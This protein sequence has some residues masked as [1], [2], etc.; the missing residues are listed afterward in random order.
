MTRERIDWKSL[1]L[2]P[3]ILFLLLGIVPA[4]LVGYMA[5]RMQWCAINRDA[6]FDL[7][8]YDVAPL[9]PLERSVGELTYSAEPGDVCHLWNS[10]IGTLAE[11]LHLEQARPQIVF[12]ATG[13]GIRAMRSFPGTWGTYLY[14]DDGPCPEIPCTPPTKKDAEGRCGIDIAM[15]VRYPHWGEELGG[16]NGWHSDPKGES[17]E[18]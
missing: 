12:V 8:A 13:G 16:T 11:C 7:T 6:Q 4:W 3:P 2:T 5:A 10:V 15:P 9:T 18:R 1:Y 14:C 17:D